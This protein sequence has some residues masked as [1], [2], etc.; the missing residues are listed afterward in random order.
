MSRTFIM[1]KVLVLSLCMVLAGVN[2]STAAVQIPE[3]VRVGLFFEKTA[4]SNFTLNSDKGLQFGY[5]KDNNFSLLTENPTNELVSVRKD[6]YFIKTST[7]LVEYKPT[8]KTIPQ[9]QAL[10]PVHIQIGGEYAGFNEVD[11]QIKSLEQ[12]GVDAYPVYKDVWQVWTGFYPDIASAQADIKNKLEV[13]LGAGEYKV[14]QPL[15]TSIVVSNS[16][17]K[18]LLLFSSSTGVLQ[19]KPIIENSPYIFKINNKKTYRGDIEVRRQTGSDMSVINILPLEQYLY[20]VVPSEIESNSNVEALKA[21]AVAARTYALNSIGDKHSHLEIDVCDTTCCQVY[22]GFGGEA[23]STNKAVEDTKGRIVTYNGKPASVFYFSSSGGWTEDVKNVWGSSIPY[24]VS[25]EDKYESGKS[26]HYNW[27]VSYTAEK[28]KGIFEGR[29]LGLGDI[30]GITATKTSEAGRIT[31]LVVTGS[32]KNKKYE[33]NDCRSF[34]SL[35]SQWYT[36]TTDADTMIK[37]KEAPPLKTQ[38]GGKKVITASGVKTL[39]AAGNNS[40]TVIGANNVKKVVP[41]IPANYIFKGKGWGHGIGM[42]Q[43]GAKGMAN[44]G[45]TYEQILTHYFKGTK[46]E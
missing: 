26:W 16:R 1:I 14:I 27:E 31:E 42:S 38:L 23:P 12:K 32:K 22:K 44:A 9:G 45:F 39:N 18:T 3:K 17:G 15:N 33:K 8:D 29:G 4:V 36:V 7:A 10:G 40:F 46:V 21:Q 5:Y 28:L 19:M 25:V 30:L 37:S 35:D 6:V 41:R 2:I 43:E 20:G 13:V 11:Q 34:L 24:L